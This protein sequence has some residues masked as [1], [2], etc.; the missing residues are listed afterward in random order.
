VGDGGPLSV[1]S[2]A[3]GRSDRRLSL[4][5]EKTQ[6]FLLDVRNPR[7]RFGHRSCSQNRTKARKRKEE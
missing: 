4:Q 7:D 1:V 2:G 5:S 3:W 6:D